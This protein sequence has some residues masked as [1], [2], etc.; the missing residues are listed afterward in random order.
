V[1]IAV[2]VTIT[3]HGNTDR[4]VYVEG[5]SVA[6]QADR[7]GLFV[8]EGPRNAHRK[9][10][11]VQS[12]QDCGAMSHR[13]QERDKETEGPRETRKLDGES[14]VVEGLSG[15]STGTTKAKARCA[16]S[17][18]FRDR[19]SKPDDSAA[20]IGTQDT[21]DRHSVPPTTHPQWWHLTAPVGSKTHHHRCQTCVI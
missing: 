21:G 16:V 18:E 6:A 19:D 13:M 12:R 9:S 7:E 15:V 2:R 10:D 5:G 1:C 14:S 3:S 20:N 4:A 17:S 8:V 11:M